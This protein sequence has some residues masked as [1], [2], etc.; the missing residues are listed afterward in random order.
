MAC[1]YT[2]LVVQPFRR[3][4]ENVLETASLA[5]LHLIC[6]VLMTDTQ[7]ASAAVDV[8]SERGDCLA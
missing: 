2:D 5:V 1:L 6:L 4:D 3:R 8:V 7:R